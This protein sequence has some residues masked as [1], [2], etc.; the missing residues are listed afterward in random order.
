MQA[1]LKRETITRNAQPRP[2]AFN[3]LGDCRRKGILVNILEFSEIL[4]T[5]DSR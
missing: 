5:K 4:H 1:E 3:D 2:V